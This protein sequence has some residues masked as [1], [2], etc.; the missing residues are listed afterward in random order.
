MMVILFNFIISDGLVDF[1]ITKSQI[2][3]AYLEYAILFGRDTP[4]NAT[5]DRSQLAFTRG[6]VLG[7]VSE[8]FDFDCDGKVT[9]LIWRRV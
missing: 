1:L 6:G 2:S 9:C 4:F 5:I 7:G 8:F 3:P